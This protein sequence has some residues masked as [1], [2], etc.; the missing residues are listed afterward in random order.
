MRLSEFCFIMSNPIRTA[1]LQYIHDTGSVT[2]RDIAG[3]LFGA[4]TNVVP[5]RMHLRVLH[6]AGLCQ[7]VKIG[8]EL[9]YA[10]VE[11]PEVVRFIIGQLEK[12]FDLTDLTI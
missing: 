6:E 2:I 8:R 5:V 12:L 1:I 4:P 11:N 10:P 7:R 9:Y 3:A